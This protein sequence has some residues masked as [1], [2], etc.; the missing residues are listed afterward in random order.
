M[1]VKDNPFLELSRLIDKYAE[2]KDHYEVEDLQNI[3]EDISLCMFY[4]SS[5]YAK[6]VSNYDKADW[7]RKRNYAELVD[8]HKFAE[9]GS[10]NTVVVIESLA[11]RDNREKEEDVVE[12]LRQKEKVRILLNAVNQ[13][14]NSISGRISQLSK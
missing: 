13:I 9:D 7:E 11:R 2:N 14:L 8:T 12:A 10:K 6:A 5:D 4:L 1:A 3:R